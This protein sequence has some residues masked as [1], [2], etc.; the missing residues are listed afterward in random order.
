M[1]SDAATLRMELHQPR[2]LTGWAVLLACGYGV[3]IMLPV[4]VALLAVSVLRFGWITLLL[5][6]ATFA[7]AT[8]LL[9][10][11]FGNPLM[12]KLAR[13]IPSGPANPE[14][15]FLVQLT[16]SP[17]LRSGVRALLDDA[18]DIAW[19]QFTD[20]TV[21]MYGDSSRL[22][23]PRENIAG[24]R[25]GTIGFRG[26]FLYPALWVSIS[27]NPDLKQL[28]IAERSSSLLTGA[29]R[30]TAEIERQFREVK[31]TT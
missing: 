31:E 29:R 1:K 11:G 4:L 18:D 10:F 17:R 5:P 16:F 8:A 14:R 2:A 21:E 25:H 26:L 13:Q 9:P 3:L 28:R 6:L 27:G 20:S 15:Q 19:L 22:S 30:V 7:L 12:R 24:V 23:I